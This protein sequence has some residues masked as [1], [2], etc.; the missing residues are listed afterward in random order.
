MRCVFLGDLHYSDYPER[1][2]AEARD[3]LF[4]EWFRQIGE[5][6]A[7]FA[8]AVGDTTNQGSMS[9]MQGLQAI[10]DASS[11]P[12]VRITGNH[13]CYNLPKSELAPFFLGDCESHSDEHLYAYFD[14]GSTRF[15]LTDTSRDRDDE[16]YGGFVAREQ[17]QW[18][19]ETLAD[20]EQQKR[21]H[22]AIVMG[23]HPLHDTTRRSTGLMLQIANSPEVETSLA[24]LQQ[25]N[26]LYFCGHNHNHSI[27]TRNNWHHVQTAN[28]LDCRSF[29]LV[30]L[31][32]TSATVETIDFNL[33]DPELASDFETVRHNIPAGFTPQKFEDS[34][35]D[36]SDRF[37]TI[38][39]ATK[40]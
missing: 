23:H 24:S 14:V 30:T 28:P 2:H 29:R 31:T 16:N 12:L 25:K 20:F 21:L 35:G 5:L 13:D 17:L 40:R 39:Y 4:A 11:L 38:H 27:H 18:L 9:E 32:N 7:D 1:A 26:G 36:E 19:S 6:N 22:H 8:F 15:V 34:Y 10:A 33:S 37:C 3:R